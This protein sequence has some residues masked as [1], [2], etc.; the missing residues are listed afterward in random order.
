MKTREYK[1]P[2]FFGRQ[3]EIEELRKRVQKPG[4]TVVQGRPRIGKSRLLEEFVKLLRAE[5][6]REQA[7]EKR[8][9]VGWLEAP[10]PEGDSLL[11]AVADAYDHWLRAASARKQLKFI[12]EKNKDRAVLRV[13]TAIGKIIDE[14]VADAGKVVPGAKATGAIIK[15]VFGGM[16]RLG[17]ELRTGGLQ[18]EPLQADEAKSLLWFIA[19][20]RIH[21]VV[22]V[23]NQWEDSLFLNC[24]YTTLSTFLRSIH[25]WPSVHVLLHLRCPMRLDDVNQDAVKKAEGLIRVYPSAETVEVAPIDLENDTTRKELLTWISACF[26]GTGE[27]GEKELLSEVV[28]GNPAVLDEWL[29]LDD[30]DSASSAILRA[31]ARDAHHNLYPEIESILLSSVP[32]PGQHD[33]HCSEILAAALRL[34]II[35]APRSTKA[36]SAVK[37]SVLGD[38]GEDVLDSYE[39]C[40][41]LRPSPDGLPS[42]GH[43]T[44]HETARHLALTNDCLR[45][46]ARRSLEDMVEKLADDIDL[47]AVLADTGPNSTF[48]LSLL[49]QMSSSLATLKATPVSQQL[50]AAAGTLFG[51]P[52]PVVSSTHI[53]R[54]D[55]GALPAQR[56]LILAAGLIITVGQAGEDRGPT[57]ALFDELRD[58][59]KSHAGEDTVRDNLAVFLLIALDEVGSTRANRLLD[60][61]RDL[62]QGHSDDAILREILAEALVRMR[63]R[64]RHDTARVDALLDELRGLHKKHSDDEALQERLAD[65]L[66]EAILDEG[67]DTARTTLLLDELRGLHEAGSDE[68]AAR[69]EYYMASAGANGPKTPGTG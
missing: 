60:E 42:F 5:S 62:Y 12:W 58:L 39:S 4:L 17:D 69:V 44:R 11:R 34:A 41:Y 15:S 49:S 29:Y 3:R 45:P 22:L 30:E 50:A 25:D 32:K 1:R 31:K 8:V 51:L 66:F 46:Y 23:I 35:P 68:L 6:D 16:R 14:G 18:I 48:R 43:P 56:A 33:E 47:I 37:A 10:G 65:A 64:V 2:P 21:P 19:E 24:D 55:L 7:E 61:L 67:L 20:G 53:G 9:L 52:W 40:G 54:G 59:S 57:D 36:W 26:P 28:A 38:L 13:G 63:C 27:I